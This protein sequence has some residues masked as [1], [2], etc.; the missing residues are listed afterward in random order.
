MRKGCIDV[1]VQTKSAK[2]IGCL[3]KKKKKTRESRTIRVKEAERKSVLRGGK[4][5]EHRYC[6]R[7]KSEVTLCTMQTVRA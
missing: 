6:K 4:M 1:E 5:N 2:S 3:A 7:E